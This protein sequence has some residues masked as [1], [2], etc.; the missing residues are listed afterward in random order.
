MPLFQPRREAWEEHF[1]LDGVLLVGLSPTGRA[2]VNFLMMN[3]P[4]PVLLRETALL[5]NAS[6][7]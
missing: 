4:D 5:G 2:T 3:D 1:R 7:P 6:Y